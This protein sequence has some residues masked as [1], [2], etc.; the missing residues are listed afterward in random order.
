LDEDGA[1]GGV[2]GHDDG[3]LAEGTSRYIIAAEQEATDVAA[4][5]DLREDLTEYV[6]KDRG[7]SLEPYL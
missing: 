1:D 5:H 3:P 6:Y 4:C 7:H 2:L